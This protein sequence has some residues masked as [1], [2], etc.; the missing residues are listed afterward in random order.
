MNKG[1][2]Y[3]S[4]NSRTRAYQKMYADAEAK[5]QEE[6][7][8]LSG[9]VKAVNAERIERVQGAADPQIAESP[10]MSDTDAL[11]K[12]GIGLDEGKRRVD[13]ANELK[14]RMNTK[15]KT[16]AEIREDLSDAEK[17]IMES[18]QDVEGA[19]R[20]LKAAMGMQDVPETADMAA[21]IIRIAS[22]KTARLWR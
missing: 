4:R 13:I 14:D 3:Q 5:R 21:R 2:M 20:A 11:A 19:E 6:F 17:Q 10:K 18:M 12:E 16:K 1:R 8:N 22:E 15:P 9:F 7:W